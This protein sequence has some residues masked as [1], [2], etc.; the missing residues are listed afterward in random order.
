MYKA[1]HGG[2]FVIV[3]LTSNKIYKEIKRLVPSIVVSRNWGFYKI[4]KCSQ[5][6][7]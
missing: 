7:V 6:Y 4:K 2:D 5:G 1:Y 3:L